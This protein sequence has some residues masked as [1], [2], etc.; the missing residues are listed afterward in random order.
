MTLQQKYRFVDQFNSPDNV[1]I[2]ASY[3]GRTDRSVAEIDAIASYTDHFA[4]SFCK[5]LASRGKRLIIIAQ[6]IAGHETWYQEK[7]MLVIRTWEKDSFLCFPQILAVLSLFSHVRQ[8]LV[9][10]EF[11]QFGGN[12]TTLV[13]P[14]FLASLRLLRKS[15]TIVL[16]QVV[17]DLE[18]LSGHI[19]IEKQTVKYALFQTALR[20]FYIPIAHIPQTVVVHNTILKDRLFALTGR[21]DIVVIPHGLGAIKEHLAKERARKRLGIPKNVYVVMTFG[22]IAW[23]KGT[24]WIAKTFARK[25]KMTHMQ[26]LIAGGASPNLKGQKHYRSFLAGLS[27]TAKA[28]NITVSG[29]V[30]DADIPA[31]YAAADMV[32]LPYRTLMSSSGPLAMA[33]AFKKPFLVSEA[34]APYMKDTD[35]KTAMKT[36]GLTKDDLVFSLSDRSFWKQLKHGKRISTALKHVSAHLY[37]ERSWVSVSKRFADLLDSAQL[38]R[39]EKSAI[40]KTPTR[41]MY[42]SA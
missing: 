30:K 18:T 42:A 12:R 34:L 3:P 25:A 36:A 35:F 37:T 15:V 23:Y 11:H 7:N 26:L 29:F 4:G 8:T 16:H 19:N 1:I 2:V 20:L 10:F 33:I 22:F 28:K 9:Q 39:K 17:A 24:D 21:N 38:A 31:Y 13:F 14:F 5:E 40:L 27:E 6:K 32:V 41:S